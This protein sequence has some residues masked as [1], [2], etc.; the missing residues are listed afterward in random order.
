MKYYN[1]QWYNF[2]IVLTCDKCGGKIPME[3]LEGNPTCNDCGHVA[4][5]NWVDVLKRFHFGEFRKNE[6]HKSLSIGEIN[7]NLS[8]SKVEDVGCY[9]C[10]KQVCINEQVQLPISC[11]S[12]AI[13][14]HVTKLDYFLDILFYRQVKH[15]PNLKGSESMIAVRCAAC[16]APLKADPTKEH[17]TCDHCKV[18]NILP[19]AMR[20]KVVL[21]QMYAGVMYEVFPKQLAF[22]TNDPETVKRVFRHVDKSK[23]TASEL[24]QLI[25][26][27]PHDAGILN[28][29]L[30]E[31][32]I[33]PSLNVL[34]KLWTDSRNQQVFIL[35][36]PKINKTQ[37]EIDE[38]I[39]QINPQYKLPN[40]SVQNNGKKSVNRKSYGA[41]IIVIVAVILFCIIYLGILRGN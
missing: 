38:R 31:F 17:Y 6:P 4:K 8:S 25:A 21:N 33:I 9:Q 20:Y 5:Y 27:F 22:E 18:D 28:I 10:G 26:K 23:F 24:D 35:T 34:Q 2:N 15:K 11:P 1:Y 3:E 40:A 41:L 30:T 32:K 37:N 36:G 29:V 12:C 16:G 14:L 39:R 19:P 7:G 13:D